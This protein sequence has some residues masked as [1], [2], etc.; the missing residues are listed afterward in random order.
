M[1]LLVRHQKGHGEEVH[2]GR[3]DA[4]W[5]VARTDDRSYSWVNNDEDRWCSVNPLDW[6]GIS[7]QHFYHEVWWAI[8]GEIP[9]S[10]LR[11]RKNGGLFN[12]NYRR[13]AGLDTTLSGSADRLYAFVDDGTTAGAGGG[14]FS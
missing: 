12:Y 11:Y 8:D 10:D 13:G 4:W 7:R 9:E 14:A 3:W 2:H 6:F 1:R 5:V